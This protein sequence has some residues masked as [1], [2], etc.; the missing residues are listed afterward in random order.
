MHAKHPP[1]ATDYDQDALS[2]PPRPAA[3]C[4]HA[5]LFESIEHRAHHGSAVGLRRARQG[6]Y[7]LIANSRGEMVIGLTNKEDIFIFSTWPRSDLPHVG[8]MER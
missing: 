1:L 2:Y 6:P 5:V 3:D 4:D 7:I 8:K